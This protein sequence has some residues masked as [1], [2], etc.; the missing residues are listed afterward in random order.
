[1]KNKTL[2]SLVCLRHVYRRKTEAI[3]ADHHRD[4][5]VEFSL[6]TSRVSMWRILTNLLEQ[7]VPITKYCTIKF[8]LNNIKNYI[9]SI[10][11]NKFIFRFLLLS[12]LVGMKRRTICWMKRI[13]RNSHLPCLLSDK[14]KSHNGNYS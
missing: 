13:S 7:P 11:I 14:I 4:W 6:D 10:L 12:I 3:C 2:N 9:K 1:M 5:N 8:I